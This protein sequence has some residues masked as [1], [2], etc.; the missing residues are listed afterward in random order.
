MKVHKPPP[1]C[2]SLGNPSPS[3]AF[4][5]LSGQTNGIALPRTT[6]N[7]Y[8]SGLPTMWYLLPRAPCRRGRWSPSFKAP[9][10]RGWRGPHP[11]PCVW[12]LANYSKIR[13]LLFFPQ[14]GKSSIYN[15]QYLLLVLNSINLKENFNSIHIYQFWKKNIFENKFSTSFFKEISEWTLIL[16]YS[17]KILIN[18]THTIKKEKKFLFISCFR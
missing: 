11:T 13:I 12:I 18:R 8:H 9:R 1:I 4:D 5:N 2:N 10:G 15:I 3:S 14:S 16:P 6:S 7:P 17:L